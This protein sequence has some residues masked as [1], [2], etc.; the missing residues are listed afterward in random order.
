MAIKQVKPEKIL[1]KENTLAKTIREYKEKEKRE[2]EEKKQKE[3]DDKKEKAR[4]AGVIYPYLE[5]LDKQL[6]EKNIG[7]FWT[8]PDRSGFKKINGSFEKIEKMV[9][10]D[11]DKYANR[12]IAYFTIYSFHKSKETGMHRKAGIWLGVTMAIFH[13]DKNGNLR[14][15]NQPTGCDYMWT[16]EDFKTT[17]FSFKLLE[18]L[19]H[20]VAEHKIK[21]T[22]IF[23]F[24][25]SFIIKKMEKL[26]V[27]FSDIL[28]PLANV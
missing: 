9:K 6:D 16:D 26:G 2:A 23:G 4:K 7:D 21:C 1:N 8:F 19:M 14:G 17:K 24:H 11:L 27:D 5:K 22:S 18:R 20:P 15:A 13:I 25:I 12:Q 28:N 10:K 3:I